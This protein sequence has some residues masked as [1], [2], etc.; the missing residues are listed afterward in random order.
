VKKILIPVITSILIFGTLGFLPN[1][2]AD[3]NVV[4]EAIGFSNPQGVA[5][6]SSGNVYVADW[7]ALNVRVHPNDLS[8]QS[9]FI[10]GL[11]AHP[12]GVN[13]DSTGNFYV[14][15]QFG[16]VKKFSSSGTFLSSASG[17][18]NT[19]GV[20][21][22]SDGTVYVVEQAGFPHSDGK[23]T[24]FTS[25]PSGRSVIASGLDFGMYV[26]IDSS[27]NVFVAES[28]ASAGPTKVTKFSSSGTVLA[29]TSIGLTQVI[30]IAIDNDDNVIV[31]DQITGDVI[32][33]SN[34]LTSSSTII[35]GELINPQDVA[36]DSSGN[37]FVTDSTAQKI[38]KFSETTPEDTTAPTLSIPS[39]VEVEAPGDTSPSSTGTA[40]ATDNIDPNPTVTYNDVSTPGA[41]QTLETITRTWTATDT[42]GNFANSDQII[43]VVDTIPPVITLVGDNPQ[44]IHIGSSYTELGAT[45]TD[46]VDGNVSSSIVIDSSAV[47]TGTLGSYTVTYDVS[48]T[49]GNPATQVTRTV[50]VVETKFQITK[51]TI[52]GDGSFSF[53]FDNIGGLQIKTIPDTSVSNIYG[54]E[55]LTPGVEFTITENIPS[56]WNLISSDCEINGVSVGSITFTPAAGDFVECIYTN[57]FVDSIPPTLTIPS[58]VTIESPADTST[59]NTGTATA[60][61]DVDPSPT[62]T[63]SDSTVADT[64]QTI[65]VITR[66]WIATDASGNSASSDQIITVKDTTAP[67]IT[68]LGDAEVSLLAGNS[69]S[70]AGATASDSFEGDLTSQIVTV[71]PVDT[72]TP[73]TYVVT[74]DVSDGAGNAATPVTRTVIVQSLQDAVD[75]ISDS[76]GDLVISGILN[77]GNGNALQS[78]L[79]NII[80]KID[81]GKTKPAKNQL[82]AFINQVQ[83]FVD[84]GKLTSE[85]GQPL[86]DAAQ[87]IIDNL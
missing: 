26:D 62:V 86:I 5:I 31:A 9:A 53:N 51:N 44:K 32:M 83:D 40:T 48:D 59:T 3:Y 52:G 75:S 46:D 21:V 54:P 41:G 64:G 16:T 65:E 78:K 79:D 1:A 66:T 37:I 50:D 57:E 84:S 4:T 39:D 43:T 61:D 30:G 77:N 11:G 82:N 8:L 49:A 27:G 22:D 19:R 71:N 33:F 35:T 2:Q 72:N 58:D 7:T 70:D 67:E 20:A 36:V 56:G 81:D 69:Y 25:F 24:K 18:T 13:F 15:E 23:L 73:E 14:T 80:D 28:G 17:F 34:D 47:N 87:T 63:F 85:E 12:V 42:S 55:L 76:V 45:A 10:S 60:T 29:T 74:Y 38:V 6:D 68:L